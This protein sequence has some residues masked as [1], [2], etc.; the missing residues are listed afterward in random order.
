MTSWQA[1]PGRD[2]LR[3]HPFRGVRFTPRAGDLGDLTF[4]PP[5][6]WSNVSED[7]LD[8]V[9]PHHVMHL[10]APAFSGEAHAGSRTVRDRLRSWLETGILRRDPEP[11]IYVYE[12]SAGEH[13]VVGVIAA[14]DLVSA[15]GPAFL[16][17]EE[18]ID[19]LVDAQ[20]QLERTAGA[21]VEPILALHRGAPALDSVLAKAMASDAVSDVVD[22]AG[23]LHRLWSVTD[24]DLQERI[25]DALADRATL[26]ADGHHR[27]AAWRRAASDNAGLAEG[28]ALTLLTDAGQR[29]IR[30][31]A[32]HRVISGLSIDR[33][34]SSPAVES[35]PLEDREAAVAFLSDGPPARCVLY[36][37]GRYY[38]VTP[39]ERSPVCAAPELAVCHLHSVWL[40]RWGITDADVG[41][42]HELDEAISIAD[43]GP[44]AVLLPITEMAEVFAAAEDGRPLPR[45]ATSF[46]PKPLVGLVLR[47]WDRS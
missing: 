45:K 43:T 46:G 32:V 11:A 4:T 29:G 34:T 21:Q 47:S 9:D 14:V 19:A 37:E 26:I 8:R 40:P 23:T 17:H 39:A 16:D 35:R 38:A 36:A 5:T 25:T 22:T 20:E 18:V 3:V 24:P 10:L 7:L 30:L 42:I 6:S 12:Q 28:S 41:Y 31:G 2:I 13:T 33:A 27:H 44:L 1:G 15:R